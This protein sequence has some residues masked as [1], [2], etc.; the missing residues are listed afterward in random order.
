MKAWRISDFVLIGILAAVYGVLVLGLG[1]LT[2]LMAPAMHVLSP[3]VIGAVL[4]TIVLFVV[5]KIP[6]FGALTLFVGISTALFAGFSGMMYVP[7]VGTV[8]ATA[9]V[10]DFIAQRLDYKIPALA[11]GFG[12]I[13]SAYVFGGAIPLLFFLEQ[14]IEKWQAAGMDMKFIERMVSH[15]T[16]WFL[17]AAMA[18]A[19]AGGFI[20]I[21]L[22]KRVLKKHLK[23]L[24]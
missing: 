5:K 20:G 12:L 1:A 9:L 10:V 13:Q 19:F 2:A 23:E 7:F 15:S 16:G 8:T 22:G 3:A 6:K 18:I 14:N 24:A 21:Y 17:V 4:G 11:V